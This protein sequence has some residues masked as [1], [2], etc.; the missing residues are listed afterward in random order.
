M[1]RFRVPRIPAPGEPLTLDESSSH[2]LLRVIRHRRG[3]PLV[4]F[5]GEGQEAMAELVDVHGDRAVIAITGAITSARPAV[6]MHLVIGIPKGPAMDLSVRMATEGGATDVH[7]I[8]AER[9]VARGDRGDRWRRIAES[10]AQQCGRADVPVIH[11]LTTLEKVLAVLPTD[12]RIGIA[13]APEASSASG[14]AAVLVGP[15]GGWTRAEIAHALAC[16]ARPVGFG[17]WVLRTDTAAAIAVALT[18]P[19][20]NKAD[21]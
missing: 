3:E 1:R 6:P 4:V 2:H 5:D 16:G 9:S 18:A 17:S 12:V 7:P 21:A 8:L 10:A 11:S 15:E 20:N 14:A 13:G 19:R